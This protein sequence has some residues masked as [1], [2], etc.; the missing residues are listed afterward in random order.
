MF[1][2]ECPE[3]PKISEYEAE[4]EYSL[5]NNRYFLDT[6]VRYTSCKA[7]NYELFPA[8]VRNGKNLLTCGRTGQWSPETAPNCGLS[9]FYF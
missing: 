2:T 5:K 8:D 9:E 1:L 7:E 4:Y 6:T 3:P